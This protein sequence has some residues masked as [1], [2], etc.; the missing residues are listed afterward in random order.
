M[1]CECVREQDVLD[2]IGTNPWPDR[3]DED[4]RRHVAK[5]AI[6]IDLVQVVRP[7]LE[8]G[9]RASGEAHLPPASVVWWRA[10]IRAR[11]EAARLATWPLTLAHGAAVAA[12]LT[13][14]LG[15]AF[16]V[17]DRFDGWRQS[18]EAWS[19]YA[20]SWATPLPGFVAQHAIGIALVAGA[21]LVVAPLVV[22]LVVADE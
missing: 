15:L 14:A 10:Q 22:Y 1:I 3:A 6:C 7:L 20:Q 19:D 5:C 2:A 8:D 18:L 16:L 13:V 11:G 21:C 9:E 12:V 4:L 17:R